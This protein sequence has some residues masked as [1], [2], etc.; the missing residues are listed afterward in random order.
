VLSRSS[1]GFPFVYK[2]AREIKDSIRLKIDAFLEKLK[3]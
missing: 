2:V 1:E 3:I